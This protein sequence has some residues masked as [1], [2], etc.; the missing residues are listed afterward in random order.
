MRWMPGRRQWV[1]WS[2]WRCCS[3]LFI[4]F[5][6]TAALASHHTVMVTI[7][8]ITLLCVLLSHVMFIVLPFHHFPWIIS[9]Y[10]EIRLRE[11][12][13]ESVEVVDNGHGIARE[14]W[15]EIGMMTAS[16]SKW[17]MLIN[18]QC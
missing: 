1:C 6:V 9:S 11:Y 18:K 5:M 4:T 10:L 14:H 8:L 7:A 16:Q 12:G 2:C 15:R 3:S 13:A 17:H